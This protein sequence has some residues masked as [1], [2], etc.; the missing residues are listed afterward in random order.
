MY[1]IENY[2]AEAIEIVTAWDLDNDQFED[3]VNM[4]ARLMAGVN[5]DDAWLCA[6]NGSYPTQ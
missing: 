5:P 3:A 4:Q 1:E 6:D 2:L